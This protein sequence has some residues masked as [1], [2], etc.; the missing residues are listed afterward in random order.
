[1]WDRFRTILR[2]NIARAE[3][4]EKLEMEEGVTSFVPVKPVGW[5][6]NATAVTFLMKSGLGDEVYEFF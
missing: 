1:M 2:D 5:D 6:Y 3:A 4:M